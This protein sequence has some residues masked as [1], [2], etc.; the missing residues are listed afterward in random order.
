MTAILKRQLALL[1]EHS[2]EKQDISK[3]D[4]NAIK[5]KHHVKKQKKSRTLIGIIFTS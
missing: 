1:E 2:K 3:N 5:K 4:D